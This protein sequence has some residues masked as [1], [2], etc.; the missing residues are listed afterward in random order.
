MNEK[1]VIKNE[2]DWGL[3]SIGVGVWDGEFTGDRLLGIS[4]VT[5]SLINNGFS[6]G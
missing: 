6:G 3:M 4:E 5:P 2:E 1:S